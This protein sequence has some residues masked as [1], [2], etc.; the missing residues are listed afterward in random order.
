MPR[1]PAP[2]PAV[3]T[4]RRNYAFHVANGLLAGFGDALVDSRLIVTAFLSQLTGSN[5]LIGLIAPLRDTGWFLPQMF[6]SHWVERAPRKIEVYRAVTIVRAV[7]WLLLVGAVFLITDPAALLVVFFLCTLMLSTASG[8]AGLP[9]MI[10]TTKVIPAPRRA[11][12]FGLR[13]SLGGLLGVLAGGAVVLIL[14]GGSGLEFPK[15]YAL[16]FA[17]AAVLNIAAN[18]AFGQIQEPPDAGPPREARMRS[19]LR[20]A[21]R[22]AR[23]DADYQRYMLARFAMVIGG[24]GVP[25]LTVFAKRELNLDGGALGTLLSIT[26]ASGLLSNLA[27]ARL[28]DKRGNRLTILVGAALG[29][30]YC[31]AAL[32]Q[33]THALALTPE[34]ARVALTATFAVGGVMTAALNVSAGPLIMELAPAESRSLYFG[35]TNTLL[36]VVMLGASL[37]GLIVDR[38]GFG[39]LYAFA[40]AAFAF[41]L[42]QLYRLREPRS[43]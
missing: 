12:L 21:W 9:F 28:S 14:G 40:A 37:I 5:V 20:G 17:A 18:S 32:L 38:L 41:A 10:V 2:D 29:L 33:T 1:Q 19:E 22:I 6:V 15:N 3:R 13:Q 16:L 25:F 30:A 31:G 7:T 8:I 39:A 11:T 34:A 27:W 4:F 35:M 26:L 42:F 23:T 24:A 36:G 43:R